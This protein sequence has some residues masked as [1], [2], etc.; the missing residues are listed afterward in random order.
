[1]AI[2]FLVLLISYAVPNILCNS[3]P[4]MVLNVYTTCA[5]DVN[6]TAHISVVSDK[7]V[8][9]LIDCRNHEVYNV[10]QTGPPE[11][12][13]TTVQYPEN[14]TEPGCVFTK[15]ANSNAYYATVEI[16][17][18]DESGVRRVVDT[19]IVTCTYDTHNDSM[20][21]VIEVSRSLVPTKQ[22]QSH[23]GHS[24][25]SAFIMEVQDVLGR[26]ITGNI[27]F[28]TKIRLVI[29]MSGTAKEKGFKVVNCEGVTE[30][31]SHKYSFLRSGCGD[32]YVLESDK[33]FVTD[34]LFARSP[35]FKSFMLYSSTSVS[36]QCTFNT[37]EE[38]CDG[39]SC[40]QYYKG[41]R[42]RKRDGSHLGYISGVE[43]IKNEENKVRT[44][45]IRVNGP[46]ISKRPNTGLWSHSDK[47]LQSTI[48]KPVK[49]SK[50]ITVSK[51]YNNFKKGAVHGLQNNITR[52][53]KLSN[54][55]TKMFL[56]V[57][58][59]TKSSK[60][61]FTHDQIGAIVGCSSFLLMIGLFLGIT[62]WHIKQKN[63]I[64]SQYRTL[65]VSDV[66]SL[67]VHLLDNNEE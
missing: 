31:S 46:N 64:E 48:L 22:L 44:S 55:F 10:S 28:R 49:S 12:Y 47:P 26:T 34:G 9:V 37:C 25:S 33:G 61:S 58:H 63:N 53:D 19:Y 59:Q 30:G 2:V 66:S 67:K 51:S 39:D 27:G 29:T 7:A 14:V 35:Y 3:L 38:N 42:R 21:S 18:S 52:S 43:D 60:K 41:R 15:K 57:Q 62:L 56:P 54:M 50:T 4:D 32:G 65:R 13:N 23:L 17:Y 24:A 8:D 20:S 1:M 16:S 40:T 6:G 5:P 11:Y 36:F 45:V